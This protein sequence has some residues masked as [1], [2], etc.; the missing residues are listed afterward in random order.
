MKEKL[1]IKKWGW[2]NAAELTKSPENILKDF[3]VWV[4]QVVVLSAIRSHDFNTTDKLIFLWEALESWDDYDDKLEEIL[5]FHLKIVWKKLDLDTSSIEKVIIDSFTKLRTDILYWKDNKKDIPSKTNDFLINTKE[6]FRSILWFW[7]ELSAIINTDVIAN[8]FKEKLKIKYISLSSIAQNLSDDL[9]ESEI[10][11]DLSN[12][13]SFL[14]KDYLRWG[15]IVILPGYIGWFEKGIE[16]AIWRGY[17]DATAAMSSVWL[18]KDYEVV[19]EIQKSVEWILSADPRLLENSP[20]LIK[21]ID[22]LTAKEITWVRWAQAKLLHPQV[23]RKELQ[24]IAIKVHLF[25]PFSD[26]VWTVISKEKDSNSSWVEFIWWRNNITV[27]SISSWKMSDRWI[28]SSIFEIVQK[29]TSVDIISTSETEI[30]FTIDSHL[31][32]LELED[33]RDKIKYKLHIKEN[34]FINF[35]KYDKTKALVFCIWQNLSH[36]LGSLARAAT[37]LSKWWINIEMVSQWMMER[38]MIFWVKWDKMKGAI[39]LLHKEFIG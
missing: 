35:V 12:K 7:E 29:Y 2:E 16:N 26:G 21:K 22:Y 6:W 14:I 38:A 33:I 30:S 34:G 18:A 9:S 31:T 28:L 17:T 1:K 13:I 15:Y 11:K 10:F 23:L 32:D 36:E 27:F 39:N 20:R 37:A 4:K 5:D 24:K 3:K 8:S 25:D 19:L